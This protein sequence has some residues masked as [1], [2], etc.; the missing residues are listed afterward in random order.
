MPSRR[1]GF[2]PDKRRL[3]AVPKP[4]PLIP[5]HVA[6]LTRATDGRGGKTG[7]CHKQCAGGKTRPAQPPTVGLLSQP[8][9]VTIAG[10]RWDLRPCGLP[11]I[12]AKTEIGDATMA[13]G[14]VSWE[15]T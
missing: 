11:P 5:D 9:D 8:S 1:D 13:P 15:L 12:L 2:P 10:L 4:L 6:H 3:Q 7:G 14:F